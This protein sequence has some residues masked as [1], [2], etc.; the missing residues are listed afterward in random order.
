MINRRKFVKNAS[1]GAVVAGLTSTNLQ[2]GESRTISLLPR[3]PREVWIASITQ[4]D[5][6]GDTIAESTQAALRQMEKALAFSPDIICLPEVFHVAALKGGRPPLHISA[7]D[8]SGK[9]I[10]PFQAFAK[11]NKCYLICPIYIVEDGKYYNAAVLLNRKGEKAGVYRKAR[12]TVGEMET[13]TPGPR[14]VPVF[15]TD[16]GVIGI[17][18]CFDIE[19]PE[20]WR[21]LKDKGAEIV[22]WPSAFAGGK[23]VNTFAWENQYVVV[24]ST[25]KDTSKICDITGAEIITSGNYSP[26]G[27]CSP[28][29]LEKVLLHS[30]PYCDFFGEIE[31]KYGRKVRISTL[32]EEEFSVIESLS[33]DVKVANIM[34]EFNLK[35]RREHLK[36][37]QDRQDKFY[38]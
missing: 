11:A 17:Q 16:F 33:P 13:L 7:E 1:L 10:A 21:M 15:K 26:W 3:L 4:R 34:E 28:V 14:D 32:H 30:Y 24:S 12:L 5:I 38:L 20:G 27:V 18:S 37:A 9:I 36:I 19:W 22:F 8:G 2:A 25:R 35:S 29:N 23:M 6:E 31:K